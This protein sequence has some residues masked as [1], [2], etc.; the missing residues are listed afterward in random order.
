MLLIVEDDLILQIAL[1][2]MLKREGYPIQS[3]RT[4]AEARASIA[5]ERPEVV[6]LDLGLPDGSGFELLADNAEEAKSADSESSPL[7]IVTTGDTS[8]QGAVMALR[9]GAFDYLTKPINIE[10]M[11]VAVRRALEHQRL[12]RS[13][14]EVHTL[15]AQ[16]E[17]MR[18]T[19]RAAAHHL[20]Q[21]LTVIMGEAQLM[22]EEIAD[23][24]NRDN[25]ER[26]INATEQAA[27]VLNDL[28]QARHFITKETRLSEPILDLSAA[29]ADRDE[30]AS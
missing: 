17:A 1:V 21:H 23:P 19:A 29:Q 3:A 15:E 14:H 25:L 27:R 18:A 7:M 13:A 11:R 26:V 20:S 4:I 10:L 6:L 5:Q 2:A 16:Q 9:L 30:V 28:R 8:L 12:R 24:S 22:L